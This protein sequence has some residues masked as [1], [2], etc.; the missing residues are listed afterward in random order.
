MIKSCNLS[1]KECT[2]NIVCYYNYSLLCF[3]QVTKKQFA[4]SLRI[5]LFFLKQNVR[6]S[7][8]THYSCASEASGSVKCLK[9]FVKRAHVK[10]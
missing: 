4:V 6:N 5:K 3:T 1:C 2:L 7:R 9:F 10:L 8:K